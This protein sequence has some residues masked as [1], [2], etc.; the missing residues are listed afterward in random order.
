MKRNRNVITFEDLLSNKAAAMAENG[1][2][3]ECIMEHTGL[4]AGQVSYRLQKGARAYGF[5]KGKSW[6]WRY[7]HGKGPAFLAA[8]EFSV[9]R[10]Q[11]R[12]RRELPKKFAHP[13]VIVRPPNERRNGLKL[14]AAPVAA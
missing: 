1:I 10:S 8:M 7:R 6:R 12:I 9:A 4:T 2:C 14:L 11:V 13:E 3:D 5:E